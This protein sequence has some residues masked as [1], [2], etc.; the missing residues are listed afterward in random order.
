MNWR[1]HS[2]VLSHQYVGSNSHLFFKTMTCHAVVP[3]F[4]YISYSLVYPCGASLPAGP[5]TM[6]T[7]I[8]P[9]CCCDRTVS[10]SCGRNLWNRVSTHTPSQAIGCC[11]KVC[12]LGG[13]TL[14]DRKGDLLI[15]AERHIYASVNWP[16]LVQ[17]MAC[18]LVA[19]SH[20]LNQY[21]NILNQ[22]LMK[23]L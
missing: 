4:W 13:T 1:S 6:A 14:K 21:G 2:L 8:I 12:T 22:S 23:N 19:T 9:K 16:S 17:I 18:R 3:F 11:P 7:H 5:I 10:G 15:E 20:Y